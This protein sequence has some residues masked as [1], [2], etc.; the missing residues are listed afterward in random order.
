MAAAGPGPGGPP[1]STGRAGRR[2]GR[3]HLAELGPAADSFFGVSGWGRILVPIN[4]RL[5][6]GRDRVHRRA[7]RRRGG[8]RRPRAEG[9][10]RRAG[11]RRTSSCSATTTRC[12]CATPSRA[13]WAEPRRGRHRHDQLHLGHDRPAQGRAADP[14]QPL[15]QR[16]G[17]RPAHD[18]HRPRRAAAHA[19]DVP[20]QRL[21]HAVRRSP[22]WAASTSCCA[23]S[24]APRSCAGSSEHGVTLMC[25][26]PAV[27]NAALDAAADVGRRPIPGRGTV[28]IVVAGAPP[29]TRTIERVIDRA[30]L[31]VLPDLRPDRDLADGDGEPACGPSG[32]TC[33]SHERAR[34]LGR[35]GAPA[36]G[37][38]V[39]DRRRR[40]G[41]H[42]VQPQPRRLLGAAGRDRGGSGRAT[43]STP[44]TAATSTTTATW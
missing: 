32:T 21:G 30:R 34:R 39:D 38:R 8:L 28:R 2:P 3:G 9:R 22:G 11:R 18:D 26:A 40:R 37:V 4:F 36:L 14:P 17:V 15:A 43:G 12:T 20:R 24:T 5:A 23:R 44:A 13:T 1:R 25:A 35:A 6:R 19:A 10:A 27:V 7:Q 16:D 42:R 31:G 33:R 41:D 29:P